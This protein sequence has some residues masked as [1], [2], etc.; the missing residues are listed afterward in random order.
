MGS[1]PMHDNLD[2]IPSLPERLS[3]HGEIALLEDTGEEGP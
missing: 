1:A 2:S 3:F